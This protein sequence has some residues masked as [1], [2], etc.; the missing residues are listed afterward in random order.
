MIGVDVGAV[1]EICQDGVNGF[2]CETDNVDQIAESI[3]KILDDKK[4]A[5][6]FSKNG[7]EIIKKHD[8]NFTISRFEEIYNFVIEK[9]KQEPQNWFEKLKQKI[10]K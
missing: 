5:K 3:S 10:K 2:L 9:K 4:L 8:L 6:E 7:L 1:K